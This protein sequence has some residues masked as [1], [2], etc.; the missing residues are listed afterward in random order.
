MNIEGEVSTGGKVSCGG[1]MRSCAVM[2]SIRVGAVWENIS[3]HIEP[4]NTTAAISIRWDSTD[5]PNISISVVCSSTC[6]LETQIRA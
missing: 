4:C 6:V 1:G 3:S 2:V 5:D